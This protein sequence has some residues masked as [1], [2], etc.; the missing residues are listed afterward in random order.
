M[1]IFFNADSIIIKHIYSFEKTP[2]L[3]QKQ[4]DC[5]RSILYLTIE[6]ERLDSLAKNSL[7]LAKVRDVCHI[8]TSW[9]YI[10]ALTFLLVSFISYVQSS[11]KRKEES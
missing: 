7:S 4:T 11:L 3:N 8:L 6:S 1:M 9:F 10:C 2:K 5:T